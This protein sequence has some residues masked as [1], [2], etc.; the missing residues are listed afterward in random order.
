[1][2]LSDKTIQTHRTNPR[3]YTVNEAFVLGAFL[4]RVKVNLHIE[5]VRL[6]EQKERPRMLP[7]TLIKIAMANLITTEK[8]INDKHFLIRLK[9]L[10]P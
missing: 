3:Q 7:R 4:S 9:S 1:M 2:D 8:I 5:I 10:I 6:L